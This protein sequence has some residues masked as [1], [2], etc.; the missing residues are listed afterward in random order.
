ME[1]EWTGHELLRIQYTLFLFLC[2]F[3]FFL[4]GIFLKTLFSEDFQTVII[5]E[6]RSYTIN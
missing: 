2:I 5:K 3:Q 6:E 4:S 1:R